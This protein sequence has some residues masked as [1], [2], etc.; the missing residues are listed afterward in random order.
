MATVKVI[1]IE[2]MNGNAQ[3]IDINGVDEVNNDDGVF[4]IDAKDKVYFFPHNTVHHIE[5][6]GLEE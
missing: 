6:T 5:A 3:T 4:T 2:D 1:C